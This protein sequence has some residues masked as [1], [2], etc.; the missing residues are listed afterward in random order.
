MLAERL[1][2][3]FIEEVLVRYELHG[4]VAFWTPGLEYS[5][6]S[7]L[8]ELGQAEARPDFEGGYE[9]ALLASPDNPGVGI[10]GVWAGID[11][12]DEFVGERRPFLVVCNL[13]FRF[14]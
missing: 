13:H 8:V 2:M 4:F 1:Y 9:F 12:L 6:A 3:R 5:S 11:L 10:V 7:R 14:L